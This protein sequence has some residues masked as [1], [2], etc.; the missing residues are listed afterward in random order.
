MSVLLFKEL[1]E[2]CRHTVTCVSWET[3]GN[4][5]IFVW[6]MLVEYS[7][8]YFV[9]WL[10]DLKCFSW[11]LPHAGDLIPFVT[12]KTHLKKF[13]IYILRN[14]RTVLNS[15]EGKPLKGVNFTI[16]LYE[17]TQNFNIVCCGASSLHSVVCSPKVVKLFRLVL[18][19]EVLSSVV[20]CH[21]V[22]F[23]QTYV[24]HCS[25]FKT[26]KER[27]ITVYT[28]TRWGLKF[29]ERW[30]LQAIIMQF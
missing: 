28:I 2:S 16:V 6:S 19:T 10:L 4:H 8:A 14:L 27:R 5:A 25:L 17:Y 22:M 7:L 15:Q 1:K 12:S 24:R 11:T 9:K 30:E 21:V 20:S 26:C 18:L 29:S 3:S 13:I 23:I